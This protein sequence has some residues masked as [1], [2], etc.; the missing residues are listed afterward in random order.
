M[1]EKIVV[2]GLGAIN[3][4]GHSV[5]ET[6]MNALKG[7]SGVGPITRFDASAHTV[8][9]AC[10]VKDYEATAYMPAKD[11]RRRDLFEQFALIAASEAL[12]N[13]SLEIN[14]DNAAR[15]GVYVASSIGG[16]NSLQDAILAVRDEGPRRVS[17]FAIPMLMPN[18]AAGMI[19]IEF[20]INGPSVSVASACASGADG[21]GTGWVMLRAG[22]VDVAIV[23][24]SEA[25]ITAVGVGAFDRVGALSRKEP[26]NGPT[27]QPF[28]LNRDGLV[29]GEGAAILILERESH[30]RAR[31]AEIL[32]EL[33][34]YAATADAYH[35]T[36]PA[37]DGLGG[38]KAMQ[39]ALERARLNVDEIDYIN[40]HG[41][42]T[43]LND[44]SETR[45]I[46]ALFGDLAYNIPISST[47][48]MTGHM[49]GATAALEAVFCVQAIKEGVIPPTI[50]YEI[51]DP[52][53]DL[54]YVPNT[55]R[56]LPLRTAM[57]NAFGFGGHNAVL[58]FKAY[59]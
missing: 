34:G 1:E 31:G 57:S 6:W 41:T 11:A 18:G 42:A 24:G 50:N 16:L 30:A 22:L 39:Q 33:A 21:V 36:A 32:A 51:P 28:D 3:A 4:L 20:G 23:G 27:P 58:V 38:R 25:P 9:I 7:T 29:I 10:E 12:A 15:V 8:Q 47:K 2:T 26:S 49:M 5:H 48:S 13:A 35:V 14:P 59:R 17:P 56:K 55:A 52:E 37:E 43:V 45:A 40:A 44:L 19:S 46:K 53:C 54:D